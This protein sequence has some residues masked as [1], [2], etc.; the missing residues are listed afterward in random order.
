MDF[1]HVVDF[2]LLPFCSVA[3]CCSLH[4]QLL[5]FLL[6]MKSS[7]I[8]NRPFQLVLQLTTSADMTGSGYLQN[9]AA[10]QALL[11]NLEVNFHICGRFNRMVL[12][13]VLW[14]DFCCFVI[15]PMSGLAE[16]RR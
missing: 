7:L 6:K 9:K 3:K 8:S 1:L 16:N 12:I 5:A 2:Y 14:M 13:T 10:V 15:I 4:T 11:C